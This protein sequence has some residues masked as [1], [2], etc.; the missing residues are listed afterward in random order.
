MAR[1]VEIDIAGRTSACWPASSIFR[2][3]ADASAFF[4]SGSLGYSV[5]RDPGRLD[6]IV[7][8]T[9]AWHVEPLEI[10]HVHSSYFADERRFPHGSAEFDHALLMR[11]I[12]HQWHAAPDLRV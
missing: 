1:D 3:L 5:T 9:D 8:A 4:E 11:D 7:L 6:G 12:R 2:S 10:T